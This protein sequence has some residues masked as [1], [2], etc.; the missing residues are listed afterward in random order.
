MP[1]ATE[2]P[3]STPTDDP[4][5]EQEVKEEI[6]SAE[7]EGDDGRRSEDTPGRTEESPDSGDAD[8]KFDFKPPKGLEKGYKELEKQFRGSYLS[9][10]EEIAN[11]V[12]GLE[13]KLAETG[14][15]AQKYRS[16]VEKYLENNTP[17]EEE[18]MPEFKDLREYTDY[19][20]KRAVE[21]AEKKVEQKFNS[22]LQK[23]T[24]EQKWASAWNTVA[25]KDKSANTFAKLVV[26]ELQAQD[27]EFAK[28]YNGQNAEDVLKRTLDYV[29]DF[30][31]QHGKAI[32]EDTIR[33]MKRKTTASTERPSRSLSISKDPRLQSKQDIIAE[34]HSELGS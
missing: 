6:L 19:I 9:K 34:L 2:E 32:K 23:K 8:I 14:A 24:E 30:Y 10:T 17:K 11:K 5:T 16:M 22:F 18:K 4:K 15:E 21:K 7:P 29:R 13:A 28:L 1:F 25:E 33:D 27:S 3:V 20:E 26:R 31:D 12:K